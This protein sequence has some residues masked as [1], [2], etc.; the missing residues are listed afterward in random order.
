MHYCLLTQN[1]DKLEPFD[2]IKFI[3]W[4]EENFPKCATSIHLFKNKKETWAELAFTKNSRTVTVA[5][6]WF[7][8]AMESESGS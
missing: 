4:S 8:L 6:G 2:S 7:S 1:S 3:Q 5:K